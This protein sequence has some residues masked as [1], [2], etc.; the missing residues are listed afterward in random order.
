MI[1]PGGPPGFQLEHISGAL[2]VFSLF[3]PAHLLTFEA[4]VPHSPTD[5]GLVSVRA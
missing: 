2:H 5:A 3:R 1:C 4:A